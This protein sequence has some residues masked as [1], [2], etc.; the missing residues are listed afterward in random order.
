[1]VY[2]MEKV[3]LRYGT[4]LTLLRGEDKISFRGFLQHYTSKGKQNTEHI[5]GV[6]GEIPQGRHVLMAPLEPELKEGDI[7]LHGEKQ[8]VIRRMEKIMCI[9]K[10]AYCWGLCT[11]RGVEDLWGSQS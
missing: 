8:Y 5:Y 4:E 10:P 6:L 7:L 11:E 9:D 2:A 3:L 1:M